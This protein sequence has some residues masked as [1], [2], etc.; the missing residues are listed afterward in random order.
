[1]RP[2]QEAPKEDWGEAETQSVSGEKK[3]SR[4]KP[5]LGPEKEETEEQK[6]DRKREELKRQLEAKNKAP[7]KKRRKF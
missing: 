2:K 6:V 5:D 4:P 1:M 7:V 3:E